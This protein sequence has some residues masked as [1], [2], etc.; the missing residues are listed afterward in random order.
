[1]DWSMVACGCTA[2]TGGLDPDVLT[3]AAL[4]IFLWNITGMVLH[5]RLMGPCSGPYWFCVNRE[6]LDDGT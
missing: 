4:A 5:F 1:M 2:V 3:K 6:Q